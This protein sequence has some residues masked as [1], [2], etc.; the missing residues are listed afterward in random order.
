MM[1]KIEQFIKRLITCL[2]IAKIYTSSHPKFAE[3]L[4]AAYEGLQEVL[5]EKQ[6]FTIGI[7]GEEVAYEKE[8]F[9]ELSQKIK[10]A[11]AL[12]KKKGIERINFTKGV[13]KDDLSKFIEYLAAQETEQAQDPQKYLTT[14]GVRNITVGKI[15]SSEG[16]EQA[17]VGEKKAVGSE[18]Y[19][20]ESVKTIEASVEDI[21]GNRSVDGVD[22]RF[23]VIGVMEN[24]MKK[25]NEFLRLAT[26]K[27]YDSTTF[28]HLLNVSIL[29]M[30]FSWRL[31]FSKDD[32]LDIATAAIFHDVGKIFISRKIIQK[33]DKL[34]EE[35]FDIVRSHSA[36]GAQILLKYSQTLGPIVPLVAFEHHLGYDAKGYPKKLTFPQKPHM[37]S[38]IVSICD[39]YDALTQRR[40][41]KREYSP[42][43]IYDIMMK[44]K[45]RLFHPELLESFFKI[46]GL[47]PYGTLVLLSD[48]NVAVVREQNADDISNPIVEIISQE[49]GNNL[50]NLSNNRD[51]TIKQFLNPASDGK[52]YLPFI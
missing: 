48:G 18:G 12:L 20:E 34:S 52:Q 51:I 45:G 49:G 35:E 23:N 30:Y 17:A 44:E 14:I 38:L 27:R 6:E 4:D 50:I 46:I 21:L 37:A 15:K 29:S 43:L 3:S 10:A 5:R 13:S 32:F 25:H 1:E 11:I 2:Q 33:P 9:F 19:Y 22:F 31:G 40:S 41:Y 26:V 16:E 39:V 24:L 42:A 28:W 8:I 7:V 36:Q 47:W